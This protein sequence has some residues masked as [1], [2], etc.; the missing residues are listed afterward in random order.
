MKGQHAT[1]Q[2]DGAHMQAPLA[3]VD[4]AKALAI[5]LVLLFHVR[6]KNPASGENYLFI[7]LICH[8]VGY[9]NMPTFVFVSGFL[10]YRT[11]IGRNIGIL[12]T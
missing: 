5:I 9:V 1:M 4:I 11:R 8:F 6:L 3:W 12:Q 10:L 2:N 7:D